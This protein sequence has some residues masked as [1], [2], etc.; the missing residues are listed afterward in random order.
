MMNGYQFLMCC[1]FANFDFMDC[2]NLLAMLA[3]L[4]LNLD[5]NLKLS[6]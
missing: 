3:V 1:L 4:N 2:Q 5:L 6:P